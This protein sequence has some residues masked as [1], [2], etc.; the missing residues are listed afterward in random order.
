[1]AKKKNNPIFY[2]S[3]F[4]LIFGVSGLIY[5]LVPYSSLIIGSVST[6]ISLILI[7]ILMLIKKKK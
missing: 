4:L 7:S 2:L 3:G 6:I 1:M 5:G